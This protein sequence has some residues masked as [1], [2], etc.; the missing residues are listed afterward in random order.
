MTAGN[1]NYIRDGQELR[2]DRSG[3]ENIIKQL[4]KS[5]R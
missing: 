3:Q 5:S 2:R 4:Y 1:V